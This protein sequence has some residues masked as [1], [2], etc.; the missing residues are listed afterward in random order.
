MTVAPVAKLVPV[1]VITTAASPTVAEVGLM[2]DSTATVGAETVTVSGGV[3]AV[4]PRF[5]T[6]MDP[7]PALAIRV[8]ETV[9]SNCVALMYEVGRA[10]LPQETTAP[11]VKP[12]PFTV[13]VKVGPPAVTVD[14]LT[15]LV[16]GAAS[17]EPTVN[18]R[19]RDWLL[20]DVFTY[21]GNV[22]AVV[23]GNATT[24]FVADAPLAVGM[25]A[26]VLEPK[27]TLAPDEPKFVPVRVTLAVLPLVAFIAA[28]YGDKD[29]IVGPLYEKVGDAP[30][31]EAASGLMTV[32]VDV[33]AAAKR[34]GGTDTVIVVVV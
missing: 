21:T 12:P 22:P 19:L 33:A 31:V 9:A 15:L 27:Y 16:V 29:A 8:L 20:D 10:V 28:T 7:E 13:S 34:A 26:V 32:K 11:V 17:E 18:V 14:G 2:L 3:E 1:K 5:F 23:T 6:V 30:L 25:I 24:R 4:L